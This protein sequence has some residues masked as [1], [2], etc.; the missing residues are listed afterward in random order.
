MTQEIGKW[1]WSEL[2]KRTGLNIQI[3]FDHP[4][5]NPVPGFAEM[6]LDAH[7]ARFGSQP[8]MVALVAEEETLED[9]VENSSFV[10]YLNSL[11]GVEAA[12]VA[13][14]WLERKGDDVTY[15]GKVVTVIFMDFNTDTLLKVHGKSDCSALL[16]AIRSGI[17]V[18]PRGME[19]VNAKGIF[20]AITG[21]YSSIISRTT[22]LHTPWTRQF[23]PRK[24]TGPKGERIKD[25]AEWVRDN[26]HRAVLK[27]EHGYS[28]KGVFVGPMRETWDK[29]VD[30]ALKNGDYIVQE[31]IPLDLWAEQA[32]WLDGEERDVILKTWQTDFRCLITNKGL[33]G[34]VGRFGG[35]PTNVGSGGGT[36]A[37]AILRSRQ[38]VEKAVLMINQA[39]MELGYEA[40][41]EYRQ[42]TDQMALNMG[43]KYL[44]GPIM[45]ALRPRL[46]RPGHLQ[47]LKTYCRNLWHDCIMLEILWQEGKLDHLVRINEEQLEIAR[48][49]A[50]HGSPAL[51]ASDGLF[52]FCS[53]SA[54]GL[55]A[56]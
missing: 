39:M 5:L 30:V 12:L 10:K 7:R 50:W 8:A 11:S 49:Q 24:T 6:L 41:K 32:P 44:L 42:K 48:L 43:L 45:T 33:I 52:N 53:R 4:V 29:D 19:P 9:V 38:S 40:L 36:Q 23:Y 14:H 27:P 21:E 51:I 18:N 55:G 47:A 34:F 22:V 13:P 17:V 37:L 25:L 3:E 56:D 28:G 35:V 2:K 54:G 26:P 16:H 31:F 1:L 20:E 46:L 15:K